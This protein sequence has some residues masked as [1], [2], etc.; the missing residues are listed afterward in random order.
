[1]KMVRIWML[2]VII[3]LLTGCDL[4]STKNE[5]YKTLRD[6]EAIHPEKIYAFKSAKIIM[7]LPKNTGNRILYIDNWGSTIVQIDI[8]QANG[9]TVYRY[10]YK[11]GQSTQWQETPQGVMHIIKRRNETPEI[12]RI[13]TATNNKLE[14]MSAKELQ[15]SGFIQLASEEIAGFPCEVFYNEMLK[16]KVWRW[17]DIDLKS[18]S[19]LEEND[20]IV[21]EVLSLETDISIPAELLEVPGTE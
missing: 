12:V 17:K 16:L 7:K 15:T 20:P 1:M 21:T 11:N 9:K 10:T 19:L 3:S 2:G 4:Y 14:D 13:K 18:E 6:I 8:G 5:T